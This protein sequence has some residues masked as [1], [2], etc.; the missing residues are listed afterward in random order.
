V[1]CP[2]PNSKALLPA[3]RSAATSSKN[4]QL[5]AGRI[6]AGTSPAAWLVLW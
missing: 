5:V 2:E 1:E 6:Q 3:G 4:R